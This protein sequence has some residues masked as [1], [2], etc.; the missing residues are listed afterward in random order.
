MRTMR[1]RSPARG[2]PQGY[3][4]GDLRCNPGIHPGGC[5][6][7]GEDDRLR[8]VAARTPDDPDRTIA[9]RVLPAPAEE[10][11]CPDPRTP[12]LEA[13][14]IPPHPGLAGTVK[15]ASSLPDTVPGLGGA[16]AALDTALS[17]GLAH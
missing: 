3:H 15:G 12:G 17:V 8:A 6:V 7:S 11:G 1:R 13:A 16:G 4:R 9:G 2:T 10:S 5:L 14:T